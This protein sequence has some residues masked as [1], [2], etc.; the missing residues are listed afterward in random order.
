MSPKQTVIDE[1]S[2][3]SQQETSSRTLSLLAAAANIYT[4]SPLLETCILE[5]SISSVGGDW[6][7]SPIRYLPST[8][9]ATTFLDE[10]HDRQE[11]EES[12][13]SWRF[14]CASSSSS[15][16]YIEDAGNDSSSYYMKDAAVRSVLMDKNLVNDPELAL[17]LL[18]VY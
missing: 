14:S 12:G 3:A 11:E 18:G 6:S 4:V 7:E 16:N 5:E 1:P 8:S 15:S 10:H 13:S 9:T 2:F 17:I